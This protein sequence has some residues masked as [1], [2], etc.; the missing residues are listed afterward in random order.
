MNELLTMAHDAAMQHIP[1]SELWIP[2]VGTAIV[3]L[4]GLTLLLRGAKL[5]PAIVALAFMIGGGAA[6]ANLAGVLGASLWPTV[7]VLSAVGFAL[8][9]FL[10]KLWLGALVGVC[11][12]AV[13]LMVY[14][15]KV[16]KPHIEN[17]SSRNLVADQGVMGINIPDTPLATDV[18]SSWA[19]Q[20]WENLSTVVPNFQASFWTIV[21][22]V[23]LAG[24]IFGLLLPK[25]ARAL[26]AATLG[27]VL[28]FLAVLL[29]LKTN[30]PAGLQE[31]ERLSEWGWIILAAVWGLSLLH[32]LFNVR[33]KPRPAPAGDD[34]EAAEAITA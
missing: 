3:G 30:W 14:G 12:A 11:L 1:H 21:A 34:A 8:G 6:G 16:V 20:S 27:T 26:V 33:R 24:L 10:F 29:L 15:D 7:I 4:L 18:P 31:L 23:G 22:S 32:N 13:A 5:F 17:F 9:Y 19:T 28:S 2:Q 25:V